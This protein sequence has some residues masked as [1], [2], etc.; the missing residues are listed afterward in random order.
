VT[1]ELKT[2]DTQF[3]R[4]GED[5]RLLTAGLSESEF[6]WH[7]APGRWSIA[8][9]LAHLNVTGRWYL[10]L[11]DASVADARKRG[12]L[13]PGPFR[14]SW[15]SSFFVRMTEPPPK[16]KFKTPSIML[17]PEA[18]K[19]EK[20]IPEFLALQDEFRKRLK[21]VD[22]LDLARV[23]VRSPVSSFIRFELGNALMLMAAHQRRHLWQAGKIRN[24]PQFPS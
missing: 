2:L 12:L 5:A 15:L 10:P 1:P 13:N 11:I 24:D 19:P 18:E 7:P 3:A 23:K 17:P 20:T 9:C 22:G 14:Y 6:N 21:D 4:A 8:Q 16:R